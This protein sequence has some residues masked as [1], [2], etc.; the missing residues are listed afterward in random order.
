M[1]APKIYPLSETALCIEW[2]NTIDE[3]I[4][5]QVLCLDRV[6]QQ[7]PF[8][9]LIETVPA[10]TT[11]TIYYQPRLIAKD[12]VGSFLFV[13]IYIENLLPELP[14][15]I[16]K[17]KPAVLIPLC[18][19]E[20]FGYDLEFVASAN[21]L[22]KEDVIAVHQQKEYKVYMMGFLPGFAYMGELD[23]TIATPRKPTPRAKVEEG[24]VGIAGKQTGIYPI[25]S[26]GGWQIIGR[27]PMCLFDIQKE[28]PFLLKTG[29]WVKFYAISKNEF[30]LI[31]DQQKKT[32]LIDR[33]ENSADALIIKPG[34]FSTIQD[35]GRFGFQSWGVPISGAIDDRAYHIANGLVGNSKNAAAIEC[36]MGGLVIRFKKNTCI[37]V[38]GTGAAFI[39]HQKI[40]LYQPLRVE[41]NDVLEIKYNNDGI[42]TY[43]A[44]SGGFAAP[45]V[46]NSRSTYAKANI[47]NALKKED[48]LQ[49][50]N[51]LPV[52]SRQM[53]PSLSMPAYNSYP[54][55]R[56]MTGPENEWMKTESIEQL[57]LQNFTLTNHC[58]RMGYKLQGEPLNLNNTN[59]LLSTAVTRGTLQ[60]TPGGQLIILMS[61]CQTTGG[62]PRVAQIAAVDLPVI[63]QL[64]PGDT[65]RFTKIF[66]REAEELYLS[67]QRMINEFFS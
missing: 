17:K 60:L 20:E 45:I 23:N 44:V 39:N 65:V 61:D 21:N 28:D 37:A 19:D 16:V 62:Y 66:Y 18:Y 38:T 57:Y 11:L 10:Y 13:K 48:T 51:L 35:G 59:E 67:E 7:K 9:G 27:T 25:M 47:G 12:N 55:I 64:K 49:F 53:P 22:S 1:T 54:V 31:H 52:V 14:V 2:G 29:D 56:I 41:K 30:S 46:M 33:K 43:L 32:P 8:P 15:E 63:A 6:L 58:D 3:S 40:K 24:A 42:R 5:Q 4:N 36:T 34:I 26:P 50:E